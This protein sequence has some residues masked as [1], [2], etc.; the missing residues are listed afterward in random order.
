MAQL[1]NDAEFAALSS[2]PIWMYLTSWEKI[3][4]CGNPGCTLAP[5]SRKRLWDY[6]E[7]YQP[8]IYIA[9]QLRLVAVDL[10]S[11]T[12][13]GTLDFYDF[14]PHNRRAGGRCADRS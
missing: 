11:G 8:D 7:N 5:Y 9:R 13:V 1:L 2:L 6:I 10:A 14:D 12:P 3:H 4:P